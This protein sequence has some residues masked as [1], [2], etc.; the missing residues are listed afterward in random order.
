MNATE[1]VLKQIEEDWKNDDG[2]AKTD[3]SFLL[4]IVREQQRSIEEWSERKQFNLRPVLKRDLYGLRAKIQ[5]ECQSY[6]SYFP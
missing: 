6:K 3:I 5:K 2:P 1:K 4:K